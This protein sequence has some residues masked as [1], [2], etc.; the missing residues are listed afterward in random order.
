MHK[1]FDK[2]PSKQSS[3]TVSNTPADATVPASTA[4][5]DAPPLP[6]VKEAL[7]KLATPDPAPAAKPAKAGSNAAAP[8]TDD[9]PAAPAIKS[10]RPEPA[11]ERLDPSQQ[12]LD[13]FAPEHLRSEQEYG[14]EDMGLSNSMTTIPVRRPNKKVFFRCN[15]DPKTHV[16]MR[17]IKNDIEGVGDGKYYYVPRRMEH[18]PTLVD[19]WRWHTLLPI[20]TRQGL[21]SLWPVGCREEDGSM[22]EAHSSA[23]KVLAIARHKWVRCWWAGGAN[24]AKE[25]DPANAQN[26]P[27][28]IFPDR[29]RHDI[30]RL[31]FADF[32]ISGP[33][34]ILVKLLDGR[35]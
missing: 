29:D 14:D 23:R 24:Q 3:K 12:E 15:P 28:P 22:M 1:K 7:S 33:D 11:L 32:T 16:N 31:A 19:H 20:I 13:D 25:L 21:F 30:L 5:A 2:Q 18:H 34:H 17:L 27:E 35:A 9:P 8:P 10:S 26:V 6:S 4:A